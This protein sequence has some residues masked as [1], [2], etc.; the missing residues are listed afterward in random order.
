MQDFLAVA[1]CVAAFV[2]CFSLLKKTRCK[3]TLQLYPSGGKLKM[4][5]GTFYDVCF[6]FSKA[7]LPMQFTGASFR[8]DKDGI[9]ATVKFD[10]RPKQ[11]ITFVEGK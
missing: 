7:S 2:A 4:E 6:G 1:G 8:L 9:D 10:S 3:K 5:Q 11:F